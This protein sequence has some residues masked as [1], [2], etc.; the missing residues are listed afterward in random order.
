MNSLTHFHRSGIATATIE[1]GWLIAVAVVPLFTPTGLVYDEPRTA[2]FRALV[3]VM[4]A[5]HLIARLQSNSHISLLACAGRGANVFFRDT[6]PLLLVAASLILSTLTSI[7]PVD[8]LWGSFFRGQGVY[9]A[10]LQIV[11]VM[12]IVTY[13]RSP[14]QRRRLLLAIV[15]GG[16]VTAITA[17]LEPFVYGENWLT[18]RPGGTQGNPIFLSGYLITTL[19]F[20]VAALFQ[21][22]AGKKPARTVLIVAAILQ[23]VALMLAQSRGPLL[24]AV[25]GGSLFAGL[26]LWQR[27]RRLLIAGAV[28]GLT[29]LSVLTIGLNLPEGIAPS[30]S[31]LPVIN[32]LNFAQDAQTGTGR[33]RLVLWQ[34]AGRVVTTWPQ[35]GPDNDVWL[36]LRPVLGY[37]LDTAA[38]VYMQVYPP[39]L[40]HIEDPGSLWD[41]AHNEG[42]DVL[43]MQGGL[44]LLAYVVLGLVCARRGLRQWRM[45]ESLAQ[46]AWIA[47]PL[48]ALAAH[49]VEVQ[50][51]FTLT[52]TGM[53][54]WLCVALLLMRPQTTDDGRQAT[55]QLPEPPQRIRLLVSVAGAIVLI[56]VALRVD[57]ASIRANALAGEAR[58][59][60]QNRD[61]QASI[62][63]YDQAIE[64]IPWQAAYHQFRGEAFYNL[65]RALPEDQ[66]ELRVKLL[67]AAE[68]ALATARH[69]LPLDLEVNSNS[70]V[71]YAFWAGIDPAQLPQAEAYYQRAFALAPTAAALRVDLGHVYHNHGR[72]PEALDQY[73]AALKID[74]KFSAAYFDSG[75]AYQ[76]LGQPVEAQ[77]A[78]HNAQCTMHNS[79]CSIVH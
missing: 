43:T 47:A 56:I 22:W 19:P 40:G 17:I 28:I 66:P 77:Q 70:G 62:D 51:A 67:E 44:G 16:T 57:A 50:F 69:W 21:P 13:L 3:L 1:A 23:L 60:D 74:P 11:W 55:A 53:L 34:A 59:L 78:F 31:S 32:R 42:L 20:T 75:L 6:W 9:L 12:L 5:M 72:Y 68:R 15:I 2:L 29:G 8:S 58:V 46:R 25:V 79:Q 71:L 10:L 54:V 63:R 38:I 65:A 36:F 37:G 76:A 30:L 41:R 49:V 64:L 39:E 52:T 27:H 45:S 26:L 24:G 48:A 61:W 14:A 33:V 18:W 4:L 73:A 7:S 35:I